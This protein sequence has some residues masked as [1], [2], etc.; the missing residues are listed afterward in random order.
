MGKRRG[1]GRWVK[2]D[3]YI[4]N[5]PNVTFLKTNSHSPTRSICHPLLLIG[6][7]FHLVI[8]SGSVSAIR[9]AFA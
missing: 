6:G 8:A 5:Q 9:L 3:K 7:A 1:K 4:P 2:G